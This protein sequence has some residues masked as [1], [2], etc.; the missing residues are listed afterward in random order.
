MNHT[1]AL[2]IACDE[3]S[4]A[5][6]LDELRPVFPNMPPVN[7]L[8]SG[9]ALLET[10]MEF[11]E[12]AVELNR[13]GSVF[14]RHIAPVQSRFTLCGNAADLETLRQE[15]RR[16]A[17]KITPVM[18]ISVQTRIL[19]E[20]KLPYR[21]VTVNETLSDMLSAI[22]GAELDTRAPEQVISVLCTPS[23]GYL[24]LSL[25][26][27]NRSLWPG[28][29]HRFQR[30]DG[31]ISRA[32]FKLLE[33]ITVF[34][35]LLPAQGAALDMGA[36]PGGWARV[37]RLNGLNVMAVDPADL[38]IRIQGDAGV[39]HV[40]KTVQSYLPDA[41][42]FDLIVNDMRMDAMES[43][44]LMLQAQSHLHDNGLALVTLK[45]PEEARAARQNPETVRES[46]RLLS[47][48]YH[49]VGARQ[50]YHN[51]SEVTVALRNP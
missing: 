9:I 23:Q 4:E 6:A 5:F 31:Q 35:L 20:G 36:A 12:F 40:R 15:A 30:D 32:E 37:L 2:L 24:G 45:L 19:G 14:I 48:R 8:D 47:S 43:V 34:H 38:D 46:I 42:M 26:A 13:C 33:A 27:Q 16:L 18:S 28:G 11:G 25:G 29:A 21:R 3:A 50:L 44:E 39:K 17:D 49:V 41:P 51:R 1:N 7:W 22:T 10:E